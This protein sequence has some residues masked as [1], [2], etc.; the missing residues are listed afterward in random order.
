MVRAG[1]VSHPSVWEMC[2]YNEIHNLPERYGLIDL[3]Y[4]G[5]LCGFSTPQSFT[6]QYRQWVEEAIQDGR[7][8][9]ENHWTES[10]AVGSV[11]FVERIKAQL[12]VKG[13]G[14]RIEQKQE[15]TDL[16]V[17]KEEPE[18]YRA[19]FEPKNDSLSENNSYFL[20]VLS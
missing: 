15:D 19:D 12:G 1:V 13:V 20:D 10:I 3:P 7:K 14:R 4:L 9:R 16:F 5:A 18:P 11:D 17:L 8:Q 2:G 6:E